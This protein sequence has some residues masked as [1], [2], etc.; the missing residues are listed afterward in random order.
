M[1]SLVALCLVAFIAGCASCNIADADAAG[2]IRPGMTLA[3]VE[4]IAGMKARRPTW[5]PSDS[6]EFDR[7]GQKILIWTVPTGWTAGYVM[8]FH[9]GL[10]YS[11]H[12]Q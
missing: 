6:T 7:D 3:Q 10:L 1:R 8:E 5:G 12:H 9:D 11:W 2:R 4:D